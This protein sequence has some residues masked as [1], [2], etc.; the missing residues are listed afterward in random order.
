MWDARGGM[1]GIALG[2]GVVGWAA[3]ARAQCDPATQYTYTL[4]SACAEPIWIAQRS[5]S[6]P[7]SHPPQSGNWALAGMCA[8]NTDC[9]SGAC[10]ADSGLCTCATATDC[11]GGAP[12]GADDKC[13]TAA[14]FCMPQAWESGT[15]WPRTGCALDA[16]ASPATLS[17]RTGA[18]FDTDN[19][20]RQLLDCS[21]GNG[22]GSPTNPVTQF[23][24]TSTADAV[25]Y[26][27]SLAAGYNVETSATPIGGGQVVSGTTDVVACDTAGCMSDLDASCPAPLQVLEGGDV[28][29]CL[30]P[31]TRC[32]RPDPPAALG[33]AT[34]R[35]E[36]WTCGS[37]GGRVTNLDLYCAK[38]MVDGT[39]QAS[40]NQAVPTAFSQLDCKAGT[41]FVQPTF[42]STYTL[43][44]GQGVCLHTQPP[45]S[46][47]PHFNERGW[48][49]AAT[50]EVKN[51]GGEPLDYVPLPDGTPCG[52]YLTAQKGGGYFAGALGY[53]CQTA[54]YPVNDGTMT[55]QQVSHLCMPPTESGLGRCESDTSAALTLYSAG[56]GVTNQAWLD[57]ATLAGGGA[58]YFVVFRTACPAAY[59]W[60]YDDIA[61]G[62]G[63]TPSSAVAGGAPFSGFDV[64]FCGSR[65][66]PH[67]GG[68]W[69]P[70]T[71]GEV[72]GLTV[73][74]RAAGLARPRRGRLRLKGVMSLP[75]T[76]ALEDAT[77]VVADLLDEVGGAGELVATS[78]ASWPL[79]PSPR[80]RKKKVAVFVTARGV[81]PRLRVV[82]HRPRP[83]R[84]RVR[85]VVMARRATI[86]RPTAC[87]GADTA[88]LETALVI[89]SG[90]DR[91]RV[92]AVGPWRCRREVLRAE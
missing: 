40:P 9:P 60:Q 59:A 37:N 86:A 43:P 29:G 91:M 92:G 61:G 70:P 72:T 71:P 36:T 89:G 49:D 25:N 44:P 42:A 41:Q 75:P 81:E 78:G 10:D 84:E 54:T 24:V 45:Q 2:L 16:S 30:D 76:M 18:C 38:N 64:T 80:K 35:T 83:R 69:T 85:V 90:A 87:A 39:A 68:G 58:P 15:F 4:R 55:V 50:G 79:A 12:C 32:Q 8:S 23:E 3:G 46:T 66:P 26:D 17:C 47:I 57:A 11:P 6:D 33:C 73:R 67:G 27:V 62:F 13:V 74:G 56:A 7:A 77:V 53:T 52:G 21:A 48:T 1:V 63:C 5:V 88:S 82:L 14:V 20:G 31:C 22:G 34:E 19:S 51:C 65:V 28:I